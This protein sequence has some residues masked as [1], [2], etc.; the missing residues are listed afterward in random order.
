MSREQNVAAV[1]AYLGCF[2]SK[3]LSKAPLAEDV[4]FQGPL[5]GALTGLRSVKG[6]LASILPMV[7]G[8]RVKQHIVEGNYV[9]TVFDMETTH[10]VDHVFDRIEVVDGEIK[11][12]QTFYYP[13]PL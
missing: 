8:V 10:G 6:F 13:R 11:D 2:E 3:D 7:K 1:E 4:T 5:V 9:A 12:I